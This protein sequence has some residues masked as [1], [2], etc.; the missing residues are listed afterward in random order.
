MQD[1]SLSFKEYMNYVLKKLILIM[2]RLNN[3][4]EI[5]KGCPYIY[6]ALLLKMDI[7]GTAIA[8]S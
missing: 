1:E 4:V 2:M 3:D 5:V 6:S 7:E 8:Y